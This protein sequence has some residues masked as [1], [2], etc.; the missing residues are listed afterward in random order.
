MP[1]FNIEAVCLRHKKSGMWACF[2]YADS[3]K[4]TLVADLDPICC[5]FRDESILD[6]I[7]HG[8]EVLGDKNAMLCDF[9]PI[10]VLLRLSMRRHDTEPNK[11][12]QLVDVVVFD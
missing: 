8:W 6:H 4:I 7:H 9:E 10:E 5:I 1:E 12:V 3:H 11:I 2:E